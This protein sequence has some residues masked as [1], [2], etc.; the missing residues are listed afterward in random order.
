MIQCFARDEKNW[1]H[2]YAGP[3][4]NY[5]RHKICLQAQVLHCAKLRKS[6]R[7]WY[8]QFTKTEH[9]I[10]D[11]L[12]CC[13]ISKSYM[14]NCFVKAF[15]FCVFVDFFVL[16]IFS[17]CSLPVFTSISLSSSIRFVGLHKCVVRISVFAVRCGAQT[18]ISH[19][20]TWIFA[21]FPLHILHSS[22]VF[23]RAEKKTNFN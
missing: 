4:Y 13:Q 23:W 20:F 1:L 5:S 3:L 6:T 22:E 8:I 11:S 21:S 14:S 16:F 9:R 2:W 10:L 18:F 7:K 12:F 15:L 19:I 17:C